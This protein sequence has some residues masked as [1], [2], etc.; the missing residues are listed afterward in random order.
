LNSPL[1]RR[2]SAK[3]L[4]VKG[5]TDVFSV[6]PGGSGLTRQTKDASATAV[7]LSPDGKTLAVYVALADRIV[8]LPVD[9]AGPSI[10]L[11]DQVAA[12]GYAP[13]RDGAACGVALT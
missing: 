1:F 11:A 3:I 6:N 9:G 5:A 2:P 7:A 8:L 13:Q 4:F 10:T 12:K